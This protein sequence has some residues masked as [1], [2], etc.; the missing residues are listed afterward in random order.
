MPEPGVPPLW[1]RLI[2]WALWWLGRLWR[3][4]SGAPD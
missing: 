1:L 2:F 4:V 3:W